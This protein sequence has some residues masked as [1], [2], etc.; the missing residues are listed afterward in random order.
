MNTETQITAHQR[1][2]HTLAMIT[3]NQRRIKAL[4]RDYNSILSLTGFAK[5][6]L[7]SIA[8]KEAVTVRLYRRY[9]GQLAQMK[10]DFLFT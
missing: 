5:D 9:A 2:A 3:E 8:D 1:A 10:N 6:I 4:K 7:K